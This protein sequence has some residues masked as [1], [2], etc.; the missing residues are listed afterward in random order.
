MSTRNAPPASGT[1][2]FADLAWPRFAGAIDF[3]SRCDGSWLPVHQL[4]AAS[5]PWTLEPPGHDPMSMAALADS[6][7]VSQLS[8]YQRMAFERA[9]KNRLLDQLKTDSLPSSLLDTSICDDAI[10]D[11]RFYLSRHGLSHSRQPSLLKV[12]DA[13]GFI[14]LRP[15]RLL[16]CLASRST[17]LLPWSPHPASARDTRRQSEAS[18]PFASTM[19]ARHLHKQKQSGAN[20]PQHGE[21]IAQAIHTSVE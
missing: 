15:L 1:Y 4:L 2:S 18:V 3:R 5:L 7:V 19:L 9:L 10:A 13:L 20:D 11:V 6:R 14:G 21:K 12:R 17:L 16:K 8:R